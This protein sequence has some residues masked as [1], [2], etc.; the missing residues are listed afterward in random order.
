LAPTVLASTTVY[1][2]PEALQ[3][4]TARVKTIDEVIHDSAMKYGVS[5]S[6]MRQVISC[7]SAFRSDAVGDHGQSF[8][9]VQIHLPSHPTITKEQALDPEFSSEFLAENLAGGHGSLWTCYRQL[10]C[11]IYYRREFLGNFVM[12]CLVLSPAP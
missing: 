3:A 12:I 8:G 6:L 11:T 10:Y 4:P 9:L 7:E 2:P 1:A 5:E